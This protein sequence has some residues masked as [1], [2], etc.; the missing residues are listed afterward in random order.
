MITTFNGCYR[1]EIKVTPTN[2]H[3]TKASVK[4]PWRIH[5]RFYDPA[6]KDHPKFKKGKQVPIKGMNH[7][8]TLE[9]RQAITK[10]LIADELNVLD[11]L[12]FN[13]ITDVYMAPPAPVVSDHKEI[14][15]A[16][17]FIEALRLALTKCEMEPDTVTDCTSVLKYFTDS[18]VMIKKDQLPLRDIK[19][20]DIRAILDNCKNLMVSTKINKRVLVNGKLVVEKKWEGGK[21]VS[22]K[23]EVQRKKVW[24]DNQYNHYRKYISILFAEIESQEVIEYNPVE[25]ITKKEIPIDPDVKRT[26]LTTQERKKVDAYLKNKFPEFHRFINIFFH[27]GARRKELMKLQG[28]NVDLAGQRFKVLVKKRKKKEWVWKTIKDIAVP[29]WTEAMAYCKPK[30]YVFS[31]GLVPG[32][33]FIRPEQVTRRWEEHVKKDLG[34]DADLYSLKHLHTTE[35]MTE[36]EDSNSID[37]T[38]EIAEHNSHTSGAMIVKIYDVDADKRKHKKIKGLKN[39]FAG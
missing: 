35:A 3:T 10:K 13:P 9:E 28:K 14:T 12:G 4:R 11:K 33:T 23:V 22:V 24:N 2:W 8:N 30:D 31:I 39:T 37:S 36:L 16:T 18:A 20:K 6:F 17:T 32:T 5:Y 25:K 7:V 34:I 21:K 15:P 19:A 26:V 38:K 1:S 27:S 29:Y